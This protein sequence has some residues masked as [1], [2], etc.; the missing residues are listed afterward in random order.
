MAFL[1][2]IAKK[3]L[4]EYGNTLHELVF[5]FPNRRAGIYFNRYLQDNKKPGTAIWAPSVYSINDFMKTISDYTLSDPLELVFQLYNIYR[6][7]GHHFPRRFEEFYPWGK[8]IV[9]DF[10]EID[11]YLLDTDLLFQRLKAFKEVE[12]ITRDEKADIYNRYVGFWESLGTLYSEFNELLDKKGIAYEGKIDRSVAERV[13]NGKE[14]PL[15]K[16]V[17]KKVVFC[18]FNALTRA[19]EVLVKFL[20]D[21]GQ[22]EIYWDIDRYFTEDVNQEAGMFFNLNMKRLN[23]KEPQWIENRLAEEKQITII[24]VQSRVSQAKV[25]GLKLRELLKS[26]A[27]P[28]HIAVVLPDE[29]M[30]FPALN[31]LPEEVEKVNITIGFPLHQTPVYGLFS[32]VIEMQLFVLD[33]EGAEGFYYKDVQQVLNHPYI[34][35]LAPEEISE[36]LMQI[37]EE[38]R[39]YITERDIRT[40]SEPLKDFFRLRR[41]S[42]QLLQFFLDQLIFIRTFYEENEPNLFNI[43]Y[44]YIYHFYTLL[45]RLKDSLEDSDLVLS[46]RTFR[47]LFS[48]VIKNSRIPF[49]GEPLEGVQIMG[50]LETQTLDFDNLFILSVNED[51]LPPGKGQQSFIPY[52]VRREL[53]LPTYEDRD[54][55]TAYHFYR[56][57]KRA[58]NATLIYTTE[59]R[60]IEKSEKSRFI[61]QLLI[62]FADRNPKVQVKHYIVN[63]PPANQPHKEISI[64]KSAEIMDMLYR[65]S[66][67]ASSLLIYLTCPLKFYFNYILGLEEEEDISESP[68]YKLIGSI[69]HETLMKMYQP[70]SGQ[71]RP[72]TY[73]DLEYLRTRIVPLL[74][75]TYQE[76]VQNANIE[77]GRNMIVFDVMRKYLERFINNEKENCGFYVLMLEKKVK[78]IQFKLDIDGTEQTVKLEGTIDRLD[79]TEDDVLRIIDYKTGEVASLKFNIGKEKPFIDLLSGQEAVKKKAAFQLFF[80]RYL[81]SRTRDYKHGDFRLGVYPFKKPDEGLKF[82]EIDKSDL[83]DD[84]LVEQFEEI[85]KT[86]FRQIFDSETPFFQT[87]EEENCLFCEYKN[88]CSREISQPYRA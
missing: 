63:F 80:Y 24:G 60:R 57:L 47:Q 21:K 88:I 18:G 58:K 19:E 22:A 77:I 5:V 71:K 49:T 17:W 30:L 42:H 8:M 76:Y 62:E 55:I 54:A 12:D 73:G 44:E 64:K 27:D 82:I 32:G 85:L 41:D 48:D 51:H 45:T 75:E 66:Y 25:M 61:D 28:E 3:F 43:D 2:R 33:N 6:E 26:V 78:Y 84:F 35:P 14:N 31:S 59:A 56:L 20:L 7:R 67:S 65:K 39:V 29:T 69:I 37:K 52:S 4:E 72:V 36:F 23:I 16:L 9:A 13:L 50:M 1:E 34:K 81:L 87:E 86:I 53:K 46:I 83:I 74:K 40:L 15:P 11:R 10:D 79:R 68:D 38:N 70:F